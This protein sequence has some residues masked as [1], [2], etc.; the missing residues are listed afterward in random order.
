MLPSAAALASGLRFLEP[1]RGVPRPEVQAVLT[2]VVQ[3]AAE[4]V[5]SP[6]DEPAALFFATAC[7]G[8]AIGAAAGR[9]IP[10]LAYNQ[11]LELG[12]ELNAN[13]AE[14]AILRLRVV[15]RVIDFDELRA[16]FAARLRP[17]EPT[18]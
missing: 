16:W 1:T 18:T 3:H 11:A 4:L 12:F 17:V 5:T 8:R 15:K 6:M 13:E 9:L 14:L 10:K 2:E 7:R